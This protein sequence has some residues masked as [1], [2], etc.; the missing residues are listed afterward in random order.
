MSRTN[1][2]GFTGKLIDMS[3]VRI[4]DHMRWHMHHQPYLVKKKVN[5]NGTDTK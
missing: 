2:V 3:K 4:T 5:R 1:P